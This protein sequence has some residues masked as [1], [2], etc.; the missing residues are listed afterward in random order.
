MLSHFIHVWLFP[1]LRSVVCHASL[2][3]GFSRQESWSGLPC[4]PPGDLPDPGIESTSPAL[5]TESL[6]TQPPRKPLVIQWCPTLCNP[7]NCSPP[8]SSVPEILEARILEWVAFP[9]SRGS[10]Q[11]RIEH[12]SPTLQVD[13]L[14]AEPPGSPRILEWVAYPYSSRSS[15][16]RNW[17]RVSCQTLK[18]FT[19]V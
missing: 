4:L 1:T 16:P 17:T 2:F 3:M 10:S 13:S 7:I 18:R 15:Q 9:F 11:P 19:K 12:R 8:G 14:P 6:S 5:Q